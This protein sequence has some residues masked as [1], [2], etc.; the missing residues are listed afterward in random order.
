ML[1]L[2]YCCLDTPHHLNY[3]V[4]LPDIPAPVSNILFMFFSTKWEDPI[5]SSD[6]RTG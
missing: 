2:H 3:K 1:F 4:I 6:H 5:I